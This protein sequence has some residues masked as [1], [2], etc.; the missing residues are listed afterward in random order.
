MFLKEFGKP[1]IYADKSG[2][3]STVPSALILLGFMP[4]LRPESIKISPLFQ[5]YFIN[6]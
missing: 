5:K 1:V 6:L 4:L 2:E 3:I